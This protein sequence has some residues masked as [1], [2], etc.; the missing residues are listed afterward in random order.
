VFV[1]GRFHAMPSE[2]ISPMPHL[3]DKLGRLPALTLL[4]I[5]AAAMRVA[6]LLMLD[7][8]PVSDALSYLNMA[9]TMLETGEINDGMGNVAYYSAGYP[10]FILPFYALFGTELTTVHGL[11]LVL[12][13]TAVFLLYLTAKEALGDWRWALLPALLWAAYPPAVVYTEYVAKEN[14]MVPLLLLQTWFLLRL[15]RSRRPA[16]IGLILG[17]IFGAELMVGPAVLLTGGAIVL[18][19]LGMQ[20]LRVD[21]RR[22]TLRPALAFALGAAIILAPWLSYT[23][24]RLGQPVLNTN[25]A[26]N[27]YLGNNPMA[28]VYFTGIQGTPMAADWNRLLREEGELAATSLLKEKAIAHIKAYPL[29]TAWLSLR[30]IA[31]FWTPPVHAGEGGNQSRLETAMRLLWLGFYLPVVLAALIPLLFFKRLERS[32]V[33]IYATVALYCLIH[34]A[35][36][37]IFRYRLPIMPLMCIL[38]ALGLQLANGWSR[39]RRGARPDRVQI[40]W[41]SG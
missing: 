5:A 9:R 13:V 24:A 34:G 36:L 3:L 11:N 27:L 8:A 39:S 4:L 18:V 17:L 33:I 26:F 22:V 2:T 31:Y 29:E 30:K 21:W 28:E 32:T 12:G 37:I 41:K 15:P 16:V 14:L 35:F 10:L 38:A 40:S 19:L 7:I 23:A 25:G 1:V 6:A 20:T